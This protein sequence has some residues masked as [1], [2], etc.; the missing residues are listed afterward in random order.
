MVTVRT[1]QDDLFSLCVNNANFALS[2]GNH[3]G[4]L[5]WQRRGEVVISGTLEHETDWFF[6]TWLNLLANGTAPQ[7]DYE[8][9]LRQLLA[10]FR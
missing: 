4:Y 8:K 3:A 6:Y 2:V 7:S 5:E 1:H 10:T 9:Y